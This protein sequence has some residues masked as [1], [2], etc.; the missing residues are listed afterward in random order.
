MY[1]KW[2]GVCGV[3]KACEYGWFDE[4][5][6]GEKG[7]RQEGKTLS[8]NVQ[9]FDYTTFETDSHQ[10]ISALQ[11]L[12]STIGCGK[13]KFSKPFMALKEAE[14]AAAGAEEV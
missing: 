14:S 9:C 7:N 12:G 3:K 5:L 1:V 8:E 6:K 2:C 13:K 4:N 10:E 11:V